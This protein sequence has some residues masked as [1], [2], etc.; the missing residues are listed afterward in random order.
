[1]SRDW[2]KWH[3]EYDTPGSFL[4]RRL[5]LVQRCIRDALDALP[6]G[7]VHVI[8][9][10]A[11]EGRDLLGVLRDHPRSSDVDARLVEVDPELAETAAR[12]AP[13]NVS[14]HRADASTT[15][16]YAGAVPADLVLACG[17]FGNV[18]N[19][20]VEGTIRRLPS[21]C[22]SRA[23]VIWTRHRRPPDLTISI[24]RWFEE[25]GFEEV[26]FVAPDDV[27]YTVGMHRMTAAP[28]P[29]TPGE[30]LFTFIGYDALR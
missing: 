27:V 23:Y 30:R 17:V 3:E 13:A 15:D 29:F 18:P 6:P 7:R 1:M 22:A 2:R 11:G 28:R 4:Q 24:R 10:C 20:D 26:A 8:S 21:L 19:A 25:A 14:V 5:A 16:A 9:M 12:A